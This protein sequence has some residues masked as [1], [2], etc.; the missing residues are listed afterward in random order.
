MRVV[1]LLTLLPCLHARMVASPNPKPATSEPV[2]LAQSFFALASPGTA[3]V[4]VSDV[5][6]TLMAHKVF[7]CTMQW[8]TGA[9]GTPHTANLDDVRGRLRDMHS[10]ADPNEPDVHWVVSGDTQLLNSVRDFE[11]DATPRAFRGRFSFE[12]SVALF[13]A[14]EYNQR[15]IRGIAP[16]L[17]TPR[18]KRAPSQV[19]VAGSALPEKTTQMKKGRMLTQESSVPLSDL[20]IADDF[21]QGNETSRTLVVQHDAVKP[22]GSER[23]RRRVSAHMQKPQQLL[24]CVTGIQRYRLRHRH[25]RIRSCP[26][27]AG[28]DG[29]IETGRR[30]VSACRR[31]DQR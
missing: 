1:A 14:R 7:T 25:A 6:R 17:R 23:V 30:N 11:V 3:N 28:A 24:F 10:S 12:K 2:S 18:S 29:G 9:S 21:S 22:G 15:D 13:T 27:Q 31:F 4:S 8:D 16:T 19:N 26:V 20:R 5:C